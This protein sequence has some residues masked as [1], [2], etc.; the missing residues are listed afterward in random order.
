MGLRSLLV[1]VL[2]GAVVSACGGDGS[3]TTTTAEGLPAASEL[4][5]TPTGIGQVDFGTPPEETIAAFTAAIGGPSED[6][7][8]TAEPIFGDCPG[9]FTRGVTWGSLVALFSDDGAGNQEFFAW[10]YGY[11]PAT[12]TSGSDAR[13]LGLR[14]LEG[15][16]LGSTR[17][18]LG[19]AFGERLIE[20]E[21]LS[22]E[23]WGFT[24]DP[25]QTQYL[26]GLL[27]GPGD[28]A[29]VIVIESFPGCQSRR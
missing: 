9:E 3:A 22:I 13:E 10:T 18:E 29:V 28:D 19:A 27:S 12:G 15:I 26:R 21:D 1:V 25:D 16:G 23:V 24:V 20:E 6:Y 17:A 8:W 5:L 7:A 11:D 4:S 14:T 2:F